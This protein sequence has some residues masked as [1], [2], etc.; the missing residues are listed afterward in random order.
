MRNTVSIG[1]V[2]IDV[3]R[4]TR[5]YLEIFTDMIK[6]YARSQR[7]VSVIV[8]IPPIQPLK[9]VIEGRKKYSTYRNYVNNLA[10]KLRDTAGLY[11]TTLI[12]TPTLT[13]GG[14]KLYLTTSALPP[15][16]ELK[17]VSKKVAPYRNEKVSGSSKL[18]L[19]NIGGINLCFILLDDLRYPEIPRACKSKGSDVLISIQPPTLSELRSEQILSLSV[20][21]ALENTLPLISVGSYFE[22]FEQQP[23]IIVKSDGAIAELV[24]ATE[25]HIIEVEVGKVSNLSNEGLSKKYI[26]LFDEY[27]K[28][29]E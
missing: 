14:N 29:F 7:R 2:R 15:V 6:N 10:R 18:E 5:E 20:S 8:T 4:N 22:E 23:T 17:S 9:E 24:E 19:F 13:R 26:R 3:G 1:V 27:Q 16:G 12:I 11:A 25:P 21:R 28:T